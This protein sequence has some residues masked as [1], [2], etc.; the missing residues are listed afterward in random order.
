MIQITVDTRRAVVTNKELLTTGSAGIQVQFT[1]SEDWAGLS[2]MAVF[3]LGDDG[4]KVDVVLDSSLTCV[5]PPEVLTLDGEV[6]FIGVY[7]HNGQGTVIIPTIWASAGVV[8]PGAEP[9]TPA[10]AEPTPA[11]WAQILDVAQG[12]EE[13]AT[14]A[15]S[16]VESG[17]QDLTVLE[18]SVEAAESSR[19]DAEQSRVAEENQRVDAED[20]RVLAEDARVT[21]ENA[22]NDAEIARAA[23]EQSRVTAEN[24]RASAEGDRATAEQ[25]R[26]SNEAARA[27]AEAERVATA[28]A[29]SF[30]LVPNHALA[31]IDPNANTLTVAPERIVFTLYKWENGERAAYVA[32]TIGTT[33]YDPATSSGSYVSETNK[34]STTR[35]LPAYANLHAG[36]YV[37][38]TASFTIDGE[39]YSVRSVNVPVIT[40]GD[41]GYSP[42][43]TI[44]TI[45]GGHRVTITDETHPSGQSFDVLDGT[46]DAGNVS[47]DETATYESGSVGAELSDL[48][49]QLNDLEPDVET[50]KAM[51]DELVGRE[52]SSAWELAYSLTESDQTTGLNVLAGY[53]RSRT[54]SYPGR[55]SSNNARKT[56]WFKTTEEITISMDWY[57]DTRLRISDEVPELGNSKAF[58]G[59]VYQSADSEYPLPTDAHPLTIPANKYVAFGYVGSASTY[60]TRIY[61]LA[62]VSKYVLD[63][64]VGLTEAMRAEISGDIADG[65]AQESASLRNSSEVINTV[66]G[67]GNF[68]IT[69]GADIRGSLDG[70]TSR[71]SSPVFNA[72][73]PMA[74]GND[75]DYRLRMSIAGSDY[76]ITSG[77]DF[78]AGNFTV[79]PANTPFRVTIR[80]QSD[81]DISALTDGELNSHV[82]IRALFPNGYAPVKWCAMGDSITQGWYSEIS[83]SGAVNNT[84]ASKTWAA[85]VAMINGWQVK[86]I[87]RGSTGWLDPVT[88]GDY[89]SAGFY[90]ARHTDFT[91]YNLV[92]LAYGINDWKANRVVGSYEDVPVADETPTTVMQAMRA[93]IEAIMASNPTCK[94]IVILPLNCI[95]YSYN[96]GSKATNYGLG[97]AFSN[98]GTLESFVQK[99]I[100]VCNY[101]GVQYVDQSHYSCIN[102]ENLMT[103]LP[104]GVH[105]SVAFHDLLA[106]ELAKKIAF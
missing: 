70:N 34:S 77:G 96:Y 88:A 27:E 41:D 84:D 21:N 47:Y 51:S 97:Y 10:S 61:I 80:N 63:P 44:E 54:G 39:S 66:W 37:Y 52:E 93:T 8:K 33:L 16:L 45:T 18:A 26:Q 20:S 106:H 69:T 40:N 3:R 82:Y 102:R 55:I 62:S 65:I 17:L 86:N 22:R 64:D 74:V 105:P 90:V 67:I 14:E 11:I 43:V 104:D 38:A 28:L 87:A 23:A 29:R 19:V 7:G 35:Y 59:T 53:I 89:T 25:T 85:K 95:G 73:Y 83:G 42:A 91:P 48:S 13:T 81:S 15:M 68:S 1:L 24:A 103:A 58:T 101:Y 71:R 60:Y 5:V 32:G 79:V 30:E 12:A 76:A 75:T 72:P 78:A 2:K 56:G 46:N 36:C 4:Q 50:L 98:S 57:G 31:V 100:E 9:E 6:V 99:M 92:T 94:I 49:R